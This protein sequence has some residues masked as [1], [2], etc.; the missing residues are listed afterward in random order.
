MKVFK[1]SCLKIAICAAL[2]LIHATSIAQELENTQ[3][4]QDDNFVTFEDSSGRLIDEEDA[5]LD[6]ILNA[7]SAFNR[8]D[9]GLPLYRDHIIRLENTGE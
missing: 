4:D 7:Y 1:F 8:G 3:Q 6:E 9:D 5:N 2:P